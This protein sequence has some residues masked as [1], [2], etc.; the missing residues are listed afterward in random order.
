MRAWWLVGGAV[1]RWV[2]LVIGGTSALAALAVVVEAGSSWRV[3]GLVVPLLPL[4][5]A[6]GAG[7]AAA[8]LGA[9][10]ER[11]ALESVGLSPVRTGLAALGVGLVVGG[12]GWLVHATLVPLADAK[13]GADAPTWVWVEDGAVRVE[14]GL[15]IQIRDDVITQVSR[16]ADLDPAGIRL[17]AARQR[18]A[19]AS[20]ADL[21]EAAGVPAR[22]ERAA[23]AARV[24]ACGVLAW[25]GWMPL[26]RRPTVQAAAAF[27]IGLTLMGVH[28]V[29][30]AAAA[31]GRLPVGLGAW[32]A[33]LLAVLLL[34]AVAARAHS[35]PLGP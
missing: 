9:Q 10:G 8:R 17:A 30:G 24:V 19:S 25:L 13:S 27:S 34:A 20:A 7:L 11:L 5:C 16:D 18:P 12:L 35:R 14:D 31:Q 23:R 33:A 3:P 22:A 32:G 28:G 29:L 21:R 2:A 1:A 26:A 15:S 6:L 4:L